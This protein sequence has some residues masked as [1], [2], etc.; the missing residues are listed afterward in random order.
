[1]SFSLVVAIL[2]GI[3]WNAIIIL[4]CLFLI[5]KDV[6]LF[7]NTYWSF[8]SH[9]ILD[10]DSFKH[11]RTHTHTHTR[12]H[13][14]SGYSLLLFPSHLGQPLP[15]PKQLL[16]YGLYF[17]SCVSCQTVTAC[18]WTWMW[19]YRDRRTHQW[20]QPDTIAA[21]ISTPAETRTTQTP[22]RVHEIGRASC[23]ER[24]YVLV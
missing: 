13:A 6:N 21:V 5:T 15:F 16:L 9:K 22:R 14:H 23:R 11:T 18:L 19:N 2:I 4:I 3:R 7:T 24:E 1:M 8:L 10:L 17:S 20:V 12:A